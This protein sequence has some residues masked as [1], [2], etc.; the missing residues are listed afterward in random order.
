MIL[1]DINNLIF[2]A[3][4]IDYIQMHRPEIETMAVKKLHQIYNDNWNDNKPISKDQFIKN[5]NWKNHK[6]Q[7]YD[8]NNR[9]IYLNDLN[10]MFDGHS[11]NVRIDNNKVT[12]VY[13]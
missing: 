13:I 9:D 6:I 1:E 8:K 11:M 3:T 10:G 5:I 7:H 2:E 12:D 4:K